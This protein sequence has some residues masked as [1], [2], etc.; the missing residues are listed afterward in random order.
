PEDGMLVGDAAGD[1]VQP[2]PIDFA[3][4][5]RSLG[6][7]VIECATRDDY[8]AALKTAKAA[9]RTT[10]VVIK[11]D[12][13]HGVPSY[14]TWWDVAVPEVSEVDG[15]RAAREEYD[16]KRVMERYFLE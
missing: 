5:A 10:V 16:E 11:N 12:R 13:L 3:M 6:A 7:D 14:E 15:V 9:D 2:L 4:N 1:A 8:V